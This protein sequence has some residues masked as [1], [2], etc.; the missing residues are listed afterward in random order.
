MHATENSEECPRPEG[1]REGGRAVSSPPPLS[2]AVSV[3]LGGFVATASPSLLVTTVLT[4]TSVPP[5]SGRGGESEERERER[6]RESV[7]I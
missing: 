7:D 3:V 6:E 1:G 5:D 2:A 4:H